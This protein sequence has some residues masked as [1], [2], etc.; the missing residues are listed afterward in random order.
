MKL[1]ASGYSYFVLAKTSRLIISIIWNVGRINRVT[2]F[3]SFD[4]RHHNSSW[5]MRGRR[6][7]CKFFGAKCQRSAPDNCKFVLSSGSATNYGYSN[8]NT[9]SWCLF[10]RFIINLSIIYI[11][12]TCVNDASFSVVF[13]ISTSVLRGFSIEIT[14]KGNRSIRLFKSHLALFNLTPQSNENLY[15][16]AEW[17]EKTFS[18]VAFVT[19]LINWS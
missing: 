9:L 4:T 19:Q 12:L 7:V 5:C 13:N 6:D 8:S 3:E 2:W 10:K 16:Q 1:S 15:D 18:D 17:N 14:C 11:I